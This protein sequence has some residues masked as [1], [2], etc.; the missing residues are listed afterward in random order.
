MQTIRK[1]QIVAFTAKQMYQLVDNINDYHL[2]LPWCSKSE[3]HQR[4]ENTVTATLSI[5]A[6]GMQ[7]SFTTKAYFF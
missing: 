5:L 3:E 2:Y 7:K 1:S 6:Q 4:S